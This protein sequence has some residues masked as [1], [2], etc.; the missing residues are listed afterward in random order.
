VQIARAHRLKDSPVLFRSRSIRRAASELYTKTV[1][2]ARTPKFYSS[3]AVPDTIEGRYEMIVLHIVLLLR[4]LRRPGE[5]QKRLAQALIDYMAADLDRSIRELGVGDLSV[6][7]FMKRLGEG[8]YGRAAVYDKALDGADADALQEALVRNIYDG[9]G[10]NDRILAV[11]A[12]Y[13][14]NQHAHLSAQPIGL[15]AGG[16]VDFQAPG[17]NRDVPYSQS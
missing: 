17:S 7:K 10:P 8:L 14:Q 2:A 6:G 4:R 1:A 11:F 12:D 13:V 3:F 5:N 9:E 16:T 15:I